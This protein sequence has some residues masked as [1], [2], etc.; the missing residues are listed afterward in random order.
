MQ[1]DL[2]RLDQRDAT[3]GRRRGSARAEATDLDPCREPDSE[4][5]P[6]LAGFGLPAAEAL[7][8]V[9]LPRPLERAVVIARVVHQAEG[10]GKWEL[11]GLDEVLLADGHRIHVQL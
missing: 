2:G 8:I 4:I 3:G 1:T 7:V 10:V 9:E 5:A 6:L 11:L